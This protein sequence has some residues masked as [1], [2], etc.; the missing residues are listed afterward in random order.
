MVSGIT[1]IGIGKAEAAYVV[2]KVFLQGAMSG[3]TMTN[4]L[5]NLNLI[6]LSQPYTSAPWNYTGT[7][8]VASIPANVTDWVLVELHDATTPS[9]VIS[10]RA[11]FVK[12]DGSVVDLDG[13][14]PVS[15]ND[16]VP[17]IITP[18]ATGNYHVV[19]KHRNH[20]P[21]RTTAVQALSKSSTL[22]DFTTSQ[23][24]AYQ[25]PAV[26][27]NA[28]MKDMGSGIYAMWAGNVNGNVNVRYSGLSNDLAA[29]LAVLGGSQ[30]TVLSNV[31]NNADLNMN[32]VV[33]YSGINN[34]NAFLLAVLG[35]NQASIF[36]QHQ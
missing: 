18:V 33:R 11:A 14:S 24:N 13:V 10:T 1:A 21:V 22:F 12:N 23:A 8:T 25:N 29:L 2:T 26:T 7:E 3:S 6:P 20:M 36:T 4:T 28:A 34:D 32:G 19:I 15:F 27:V 31:Y 35:G 17:S 5:R 9:V 30:S 16:T